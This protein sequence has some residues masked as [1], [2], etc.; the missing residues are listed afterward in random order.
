MS[1][2]E[3]YIFRRVAL[4]S[5]A[6][7]LAT[8][9]VVL[10][11]QVLRH[12]NVLTDS[13]RALLSFLQLAGLLA[14]VMAGVVAP[15][16]VLIGVMQV[17][18]AM[19]SDSETA[20]MESSGVSHARMARPV[21]LFSALVSVAMLL[22]ANGIEPLANRQLRSMVTSARGDLF[23]HAVQSGTFKKLDDN[24]Y[25]QIADQLAG[26][27]LAGIFISDGRDPATEL[28]YYARRGV[29]R[30]VDGVDVLLLADG[31]IHRKNRADGAVSIISFVSYALSLSDL[32]PQ[33]GSTTY[34]P[35]ERTTSNLLWPDPN[36]R[37]N[38]G[39]PQAVRA[40]LH[41][42]LS[43]WLY[44]LAFGLIGFAYAGG[45]QSSRQER[46]WSIATA[47]LIALGFRVGGYIC[48]NMAGSSSVIS[49]LC[50]I[51]P[52]S[53]ISLFGGL[54]LSGRAVVLPRAAA[55]LAAWSRGRNPLRRAFPKRAEPIAARGRA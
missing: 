24:L 15:F 2:I 54:A 28:I 7:L 40:E 23:Q 38:R 42:R 20:V 10:I 6:A 36:D 41:Q 31:E 30:T 32:T 48:A 55:R 29:V 26:G 16:A 34:G 49:A 12:V 27:Q 19:N 43:D 18:N 52:L 14:P 35:N 46:M 11:T 1:L 13:N 8:T 45:A 53:A 3:R 17:L 47:T 21:I 50:Y 4:L 9:L 25:V 22:I 51:I 33:E 44:P 39:K 5:L 37:I